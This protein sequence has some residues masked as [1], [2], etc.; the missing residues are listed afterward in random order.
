MCKSYRV[1]SFLESLPL[2]LILDDPNSTR[3]NKA[4]MGL[5]KGDLIVPGLN[6][7][8][9]IVDA[10]SIDLCSFSNEHLIN[11]DVN[12]PLLAVEKTKLLNTRNLLLLSMKILV[13]NITY[14]LL[15]FLTLIFRLG[16][17]DFP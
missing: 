13:L 4:S 16:C 3:Y 12:N 15:F 8:F 9:S 2:K 11:S 10:M 1:D 6:V 5:A 14:V 17:L 7:S